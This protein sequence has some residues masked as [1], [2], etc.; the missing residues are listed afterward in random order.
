MTRNVE[1]SSIDLRY[2]GHR[3]RN[4]TQEAKLL[5]S[6]Q[7]RGVEKPLRG[8][9]LG[10]IAILLDGFKRCRCARR[11][12]IGHLP[13]SSIGEDCA[14]GIVAVMRESTEKGLTIL[15]QA[16]FVTELHRTHGMEVAEIADVLSRSR[17]WV[18]MRLE[19]VGEMSETVR[20]KVFAGSFPAY[21]Y[22]YTLRT[23]LRKKG[24]SRAEGDAFVRAVS[25]KRLSIREIDQLANGYFRGPEWFRGEIDDGHLSLVLS[26]MREMP[27]DPGAVDDFERGLLK[28]LETLSRSMLRV[29]EKSVVE[30]EW[31]PAFRVQAN[32][33]LAGILSRFGAVKKAL[34]V[35]HDRTGAA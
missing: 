23:F 19:L 14:S 3:M 21:S 16:R 32:L 6:I 13:F 27:R 7:E 2:E 22:M 25:G 17:S 5:V 12:S 35:L 24:V 20:E 28:D 18:F 8:I 11:L 31:T 33:L 1:I 29:T 9:L 4:R 26:R 34:E 30:R 15:E 10:E